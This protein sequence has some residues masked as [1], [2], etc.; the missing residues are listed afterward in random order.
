M[1]V[2]PDETPT[3]RLTNRLIRVPVQVYRLFP[4]EL[5]FTPHVLR[6]VL[7]VGIPAGLQSNMYT[8]SNMIIQSAINT[9]GTKRF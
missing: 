7:K 4:E 6:S 2:V 1:T 3:N 5:K 9:F 8:I